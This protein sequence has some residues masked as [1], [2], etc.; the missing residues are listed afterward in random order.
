MG[1]LANQS[2]YHI[3]NNHYF[4]AYYH[5]FL[6]KCGLLRS[7]Q[8]VPRLFFVCPRRCIDNRRLLALKARFVRERRPI[9]A[10]WGFTWGYL[11]CM[12]YC[13]EVD[14]LGVP[15]FLECLLKFISWKFPELDDDWGYTPMD[16]KPPYEFV[17]N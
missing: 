14:D 16:W 9:W 7:S 15:P 13:L 4:L 11:S 12:V 1:L 3:G 10:I 5:M 8:F 6:P 2:H 17:R